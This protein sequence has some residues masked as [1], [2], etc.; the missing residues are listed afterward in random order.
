MTENTTSIGSLLAGSA[1][2]A[3]T[4]TGLR[5]L[6]AAINGQGGGGPTSQIMMGTVSAV[7]LTG[8]PPTIDC[9]LNGDTTTLVTGIVFMDSYTPLV[10]DVVHFMEQGN[11]VFAMGQAAPGG[12]ATNNGWVAPTGFTAGGPGGSPLARLRMQSGS[13][14]VEFQGTVAYAGTLLTVPSGMAPTTAPRPL[15]APSDGLGFVRLLVNTNG[16][17]TV[18][19]P[20]ANTGNTSPGTDSQSPGASSGSSSDGFGG[21]TGGASAGTAHTHSEGGTTNGHSHSVS[22]NSH[23]HTVNSHSHSISSTPTW[24]GLDGLSYYL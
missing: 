5:A 8:T 15:I 21:T 12:S 1:T 24:V 16:T 9:Y 18:T 20:S 22:V 11:T 23:S 3:Q 17:V 4:Q 13:V 19:L 14:Q 7:H 2:A 6:A 10:G